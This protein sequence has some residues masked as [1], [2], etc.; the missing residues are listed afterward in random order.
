M[1]LSRANTLPSVEW[2]SPPLEDNSTMTERDVLVAV[3]LEPPQLLGEGDHPLH[4]A[5][6]ACKVRS[7]QVRSAA[8]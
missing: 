4:T 5:A 3:D 6:H 8:L 1:L 7:G 2:D